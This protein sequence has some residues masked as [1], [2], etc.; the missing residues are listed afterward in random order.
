MTVDE[1]G[2]VVDEVE[3]RGVINEV[4]VSYIKQTLIA[5]SPDPDLRTKR[6]ARLLPLRTV[7]LQP[8][9]INIISMNNTRICL[10]LRCV[11]SDHEVAN[12]TN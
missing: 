5:W 12:H 2:A 10:R 6:P 4:A 3:N 8:L 9:F 1:E 11:E 7:Y